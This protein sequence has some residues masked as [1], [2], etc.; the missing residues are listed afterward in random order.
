MMCHCSHSQRGE[1]K[2]QHY[3][4]ETFHNN[5]RLSTEWWFHRKSQ[6]ITKISR[7]PCSGTWMSTQNVIEIHPTVVETFQSGLK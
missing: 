7:T 5:T 4:F 1:T 6:V 2:V 3:R